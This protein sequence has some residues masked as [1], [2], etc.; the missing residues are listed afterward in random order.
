M[1][2]GK[3]G[4]NRNK[5]AVEVKLNRLF[6]ATLDE[7]I[8][9]VKIDRDCDKTDALR[10]LMELGL[11]NAD[12][13][14]GDFPG[15]DNESSSLVLTPE[16]YADSKKYRLRYTLDSKTDFFFDVISRGATAWLKQNASEASTAVSSGT[17]PKSEPTQEPEP[18]ASPEKPD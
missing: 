16:Q 18:A 3:G 15:I 17:S 6:P 7:V 10:Y 4:K 11:A 14:I 12:L 8:R 9:K 2:K 5:D 13:P 1:A